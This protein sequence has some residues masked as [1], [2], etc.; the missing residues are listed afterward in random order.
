MYFIF[1]VCDTSVKP[2]S[3]IS[4]DMAAVITQE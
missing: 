3:V 2:E 4:V 1:F